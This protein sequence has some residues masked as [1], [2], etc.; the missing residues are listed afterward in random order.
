M[1]EI[2][3]IGLRWLVIMLRL[4]S[5]VDMLGMLMDSWV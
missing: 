5:G 3:E 4:S 2:G 1:F